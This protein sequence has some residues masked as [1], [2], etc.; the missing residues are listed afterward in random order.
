VDAPASFSQFCSSGAPFGPRLGKCFTRLSLHICWCH[1]VPKVLQET[2]GSE[3]FGQT[4]L[5]KPG[6][7]GLRNQS[8]PSLGWACY[9]GDFAL[10]DD[11]RA[12]FPCQLPPSALSPLGSRQ[13]Q[14]VRMMSLQSKKGTGCC[15]GHK[16]TLAE[17]PFTQTVLGVICKRKLESG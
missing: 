14:M 6:S 15:S 10:G 5:P 8:S 9:Q 2:E 11:H 16:L 4:V 12:L 7:T 3:L 13:T 1:T 17:P